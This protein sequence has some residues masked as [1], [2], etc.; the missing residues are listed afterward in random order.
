MPHSF[1]LF[2]ELFHSYVAVKLQHKLCVNAAT[3]HHALIFNEVFYT[4]LFS[5]DVANSIPI[6]L[7][8]ICLCPIHSDVVRSFLNATGDKKMSALLLG[9]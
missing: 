1:D 3:F 2:I 6:E 7:N 5:F 4:Y 9:D 8:R